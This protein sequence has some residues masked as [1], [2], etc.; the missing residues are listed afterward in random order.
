MILG[1]SPVSNE[2]CKTVKTFEEKKGKRVV[3][4][5]IGGSVSLGLSNTVSDYD[6]YILYEKEITEWHSIVKINSKLFDCCSDRFFDCCSDVENFYKK[7]SLYP[8]VIYRNL[9]ERSDDAK[10]GLLTSIFLNDTFYCCDD[11]FQSGYDSVKKLLVLREVCD[12][13]F[14]RAYGNW[15]KFIKDK[16]EVLLRKYLYTAWHCLYVQKL[17][18]TNTAC[19]QDFKTILTTSAKF[20]GNVVYDELES[21]YYTNLSAKIPKERYY[22]KQNRILNEWIGKVLQKQEIAIHALGSELI[23]VPLLC[24]NERGGGGGGGTTYVT[25]FYCFMLFVAMPCTRSVD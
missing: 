7:K 24:I 9:N 18:E 21:L 4:A 12:F 6:L 20:T 3:A 25:F 14:T 5:S 22:I 8:S 15:N 16:S 17:I 1:K 23:F 13:C 19:C 11:F 2:L 10:F